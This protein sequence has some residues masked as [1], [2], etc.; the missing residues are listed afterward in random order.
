M[1]DVIQWARLE[2]LEPTI[3]ALEPLEACYMYLE[4]V[5]DE[6]LTGED[7]RDG[8]RLEKFE[9]DED[10]DRWERGRIFCADFELRWERL[11]GAFQAVYVG[12]PQELPGFVPADELN[13]DGT[14]VEQRSYMLWGNKVPADDLETV[15]AEKREGQ[16]AFIEFQVP[17]VFYYPASDQAQR[18]RLQV[19]EYVD[20]GSGAR[21]YHRFLGLEE[22]Q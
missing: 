13:L 11:D 15:G 9:P 19:R 17:R 5:P 6:W 21:C 7:R 1:T 12:A 10:F 18:V 16:S 14:K 2:T 22:I 4:R 3:A 8:L 20:P